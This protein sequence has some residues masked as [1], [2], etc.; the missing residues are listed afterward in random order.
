METIYHLMRG[1]IQKYQINVHFMKKSF[2]MTVQKQDWGEYTRYLIMHEHGTVFLN[3]YNK[4]Q[5]N[6]GGN[7]SIW[8]LFVS[9][10][11]RRNGIGKILLE[12][13]ERLART[14]GCKSVVLE[15]D[16]K[17]TPREILDWYLRFGYGVVGHYRAEQYMLEKKLSQ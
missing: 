3:V 12:E 2:Q 14:L 17:S 7:A 5:S 1:L 6:F 9:P 10:S 4:V 13:A 16:S 11:E 8:G 15:W